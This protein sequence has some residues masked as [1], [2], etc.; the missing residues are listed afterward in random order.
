T[1]FNPDLGTQELPTTLASIINTILGLLGIVAVV[2]VLYAGFL[3]MTA[4][5]NDEKIGT[6]KKILSA[7]IFGLI[8][9]FSAYAIAQFALSKIIDATKS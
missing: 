4:A 6:A 8:I 7:G 9:I 5:G 1:D 2:L 3:W